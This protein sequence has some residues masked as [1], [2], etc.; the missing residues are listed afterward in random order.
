MDQQLK[1]LL[2]AVEGGG[3]GEAEIEFLDPPG[4][5]D[6]R[7]P[8]KERSQYTLKALRELYIPGTDTPSVDPEDEKY[9][10]LFMTIEEEIAEYYENYPDLTDGTVGLALD[11]LAMDPDSPPAGDKLAQKIVLGLRLCLSLW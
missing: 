1:D 4:T 6:V 5:I 9:M 2:G 7:P 3:K 8:K 10:P 11:Q